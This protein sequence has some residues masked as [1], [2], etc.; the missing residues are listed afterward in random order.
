MIYLKI[1]CAWLADSAGLKG[2][3]GKGKKDCP[4][5]IKVSLSH[6]IDFSK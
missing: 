1:V 5:K 4:Y 3:K 6:V 2:S